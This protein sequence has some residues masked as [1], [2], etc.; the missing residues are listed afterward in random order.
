[1]FQLVRTKNFNIFCPSL[2]LDGGL[3][4][5]VGGALVDHLVQGVGVLTELQKYSGLMG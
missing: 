2:R 3:E 4:V 1:M 5:G